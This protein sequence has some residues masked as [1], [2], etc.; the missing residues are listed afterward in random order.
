MFFIHTCCNMLMTYTFIYL[1]FIL[2]HY[3]MLGLLSHHSTLFCSS[4]AVAAMRYAETHEIFAMILVSA[5]VTD[6]G[7]ETERK[8]G[9][10]NR[11]WQWS[12]MKSH[13]KHIIQFGSSDD[14]FLPWEEQTLVAK[15]TNSQFHKSDQAGHYMNSVFPELVKVVK[16]LISSETVT[17]KCDDFV[18]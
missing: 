11:P 18:I 17:E 14:P 10:F 4:G 12:D 3:C 15:E 7:D 6:L 13:C 5:Y 9:Y 8:S 2:Q 1:L 16:N